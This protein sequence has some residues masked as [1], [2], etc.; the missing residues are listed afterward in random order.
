MPAISDK[1]PVAQ[2]FESLFIQAWDLFEEL[3]YDEVSA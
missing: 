1:D 3:K 2:V